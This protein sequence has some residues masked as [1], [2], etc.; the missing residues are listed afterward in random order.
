M[1][2][3]FKHKKRRQESAG[4][5]LRKIIARKEISIKAYQRSLVL[6]FSRSTINCMMAS[7]S[8]SSSVRTSAPRFFTSALTSPWLPP[9]LIWFITHSTLHV[10]LNNA[11]SI[12]FFIIVISFFYHLTNTL[13]T[14]P[15]LILITFMPFWRELRWAPS[16]P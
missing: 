4:A 14:E 16:M 10:S 5:I 3:L 1:F 2:L 12:Y 7:S 13:R 6:P 9:P 8:I 11:G 15:L